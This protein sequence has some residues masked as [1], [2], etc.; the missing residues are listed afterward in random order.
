M[1]TERKGGKLLTT[2]EIRLFLTE[3]E[4]SVL[5]KKAREGQR[6]YEGRHDIL[7][8]RLF[9]YNGDG[10]LVED[11]NRTN[12][13]IPHPFFTELVDQA[14]LY[15]LS[16]D[17]GIFGADDPKLQKFLDL[18]FN[19]NETFAAELAE[20]ITG[21]QAKG[22]DYMY[23]YKDENDRLAFENADCLGVVEVEGRFAEDG[24]NQCIYKYVD[25]IDKEN[26]TQWKI[27]VIDDEQT[28]YYKQ[29][30][31]GEIQTDTEVK[32]NPRPHNIYIDKETG[33]LARKT[34]T[35]NFLPMFRL[36]NNKKRFSHLKSVKLLIDDYD[37]MAS[38]LSNNLIDF[39]TPLH[40]VKGYE[41]D[42]L[43]ELQQNLKTKKIIGVDSEGGVEVR[44]V[45]IPYQARQAKLELDERSIYKFGF[46][47]NM[48]GLK[49]T[50]ATTNIAIKMAYSLLELRSGKIITELK[51]FLR[52]LLK[53]VIA[54]INEQNDTDYQVADV[55][56]R[57]KPESMANVSENAQN[58]LVE[59]QEQQVRINTLLGLAT[60]FDNETLMQNI[61]DILDIDY[62]EVK[63]S[64]PNPDE[65][66]QQLNAA[67]NGLVN[68]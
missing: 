41:G 35:K 13:K 16:G 29:T 40:V 25:R 32:I 8:Y 46:G 62:E 27:L 4:A 26:H 15:V 66:A 54:E 3:D 1:Q 30:D 28:A 6:Y 19:D 12:T 64:L 23:A 17:D 44:T 39:D 31:D 59:A 2:D 22:F 51:K 58:K 56:F 60:Y 38:S 37:I 55:Y 53:P 34:T 33:K 52:Q 10:E 45:D 68:A 36:D 63:G 65:A 14:V 57:F 21:Q 67:Q 50:A 7:E 43:D 18:Y 20:T 5:K 24:K 47:L 9:Y 61:C 49:D 11:K 48:A 42:N